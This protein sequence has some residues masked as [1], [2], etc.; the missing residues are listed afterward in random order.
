MVPQARKPAA[1]APGVDALQAAPVLARSFT[2]MDVG[3]AG[4]SV[5]LTRSELAE[6]ETRAFGVTTQEQHDINCSSGENVY[7]FAQM[8]VKA[9]AAVF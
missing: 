7:T 1:V 8:L 4:V 3:C 9:P 6:R 5:L 2:T